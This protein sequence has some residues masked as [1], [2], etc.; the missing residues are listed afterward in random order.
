MDATLPELIAD[1]VSAS[2]D[3]PEMTL[4]VLANDIFPADYAGPGLITSVSFG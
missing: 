4:D 1:N 2:T 3:G